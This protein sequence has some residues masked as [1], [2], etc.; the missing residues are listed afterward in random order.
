LRRFPV[1]AS[2]F[3]EYKRNSPDLSLRIMPA[4]MLSSAMLAAQDSSRSQPAC[5]T[6]CLSEASSNDQG[7]REPAFPDGYILAH[8]EG[9]SMA[10]RPTWTGQLRISLVSFGIQL[11]P[12]TSST[13]E[14]TFH[15]VDRK[16]HQRIHH[17]NVI[18]GDQPVANADIVKGYEYSKGKYLIIEPE[19]VKRLRIETKNT[20]NIAEFVDWE[21]LPPYL[22]ENPYFLVPDP[23]GSSE[24]FA[25]VR[26]AMVQARKVAI[27]EVAFGGREHLVAIAPHPDKNVRGLMAYTLRYAEELRNAK[28]FLSSIGKHPI[29]KKQL[30]LAN[31]LI[32]A[33]SAPFHLND[34]KD[35]FEAALH[36]LIEAKRAQKPLPV[37]EAKPR[38]KVISL[39]DALKRSVRESNQKEDRPRAGSSPR[40]ST[41]GPKL[42]K[43]GKRSHQAA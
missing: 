30:A 4:V 27:G 31:D 26:A 11:F 12:A 28:D 2:F 7:V 17:L 35:D 39:M 37:A 8:A 29:D 41:K 15:Q 22:F 20:I 6:T 36:E 14:V 42:V 19:E 10:G 23:K 9:G 34:Y 40:S 25:V 38:A 32:R 3:R 21:D 13:S 43:S 16:T 18:D 1:A 24:A 5:G 33:H